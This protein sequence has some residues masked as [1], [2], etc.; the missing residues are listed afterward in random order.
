M[1][2][3]VSPHI[4]TGFGFEITQ[5]LTEIQR[6]V[7]LSNVI[8]VRTEQKR[9]PPKNKPLPGPEGPNPPQGQSTLWQT[10]I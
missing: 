8:I 10:L 7:Q 1:K 6:K 9:P 2:F 5:K 3:N 4:G